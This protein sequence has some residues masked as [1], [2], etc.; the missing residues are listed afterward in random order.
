MAHASDEKFRKTG[1]GIGLMDNFLASGKFTV[2][3]MRPPPPPSRPKKG[4][5]GQP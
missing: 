2:P 5:I 1:L 4:A 3:P